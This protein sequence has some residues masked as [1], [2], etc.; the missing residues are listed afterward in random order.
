MTQQPPA[1]HRTVRVREGTP[2]DHEAAVEVWRTAN[3]A[4]RRGAPAP[5]EHERR[6]RDRFGLPAVW[7]LV[8]DDDGEVVGVTSGMA[9][10]DDDGAGAVIAGRC[11]LS[12]VFVRPDRW[13]RGIGGDL[14][15]GALEEARRRGYQRIQLWTHEDNERAQ[16][17]YTRRG[18]ARTGRTKDDDTGERIGLWERDL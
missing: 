3:E 11:H 12:L 10:R 5:A 2:P 14:V 9:A 6:V 17:L 15:D 13:G 1:G 18:F 16:R 4:R 7:L 8:A